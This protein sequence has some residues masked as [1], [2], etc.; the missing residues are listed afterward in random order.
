MNK[1]TRE[2]KLAGKR[3]WYYDNIEKVKASSK[4]SREKHKDQRK[5]D[6]KNWV[7]KNKKYLSTYRKENY[8]GIYG[9]WYAMKQRIGNP[10][11]SSYHNY[12]GRGLNYDTQ[13]ETFA[14]F[15]KDMGD[16]YKKGFTLER[17]N[18][19]GNYCKENCRWATRKDQSNNTRKNILIKYKSIELTSSQWAEKLG[20]KEGTFKSRR[21][22]G[23]TLERMM[24]QKLERPAKLLT[25]KRI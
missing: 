16:T 20:L 3:K 15:E 2:Q 5:L 10:K 18:N 25:I 11:H 4:K 8:T 12:G 21:L 24:N 7:E 19:N 22:R 17:I 1:A 9:S 6:N 13:W 23:W 14:G